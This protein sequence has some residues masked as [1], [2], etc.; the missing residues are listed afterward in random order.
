M[1]PT[2]QSARREALANMEKRPRHRCGET[3]TRVRGGRDTRAGKPRHYGSRGHV[4]VTPPWQKT[5]RTNIIIFVFWPN[6]GYQKL[7]PKTVDAEMLRRVGEL[8]PG[9]SAAPFNAGAHRS[10][11]GFRI[12]IPWQVLA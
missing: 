4:L 12:S 7:A 1:R 3:A 6:F 10:K 11:R 9:A 8:T 2:A 5:L